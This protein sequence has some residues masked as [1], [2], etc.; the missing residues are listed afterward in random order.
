MTTDPF[1][2]PS[3]ESAA[4]A[5]LGKGD[6]VIV[7]AG[8]PV[9]GNVTEGVAGDVTMKDLIAAS[10]NGESQFTLLVV[11]PIDMISLASDISELSR[12]GRKFKRIVILSHAGGPEASPSIETKDGGK[13]TPK[14]VTKGLVRAVKQALT[15][16]GIV[17]MA[18][19]GY[20]YED[21]K[22]V[23]G[24]RVYR[25]RGIDP[26]LAK[27][28][29]EYQ[30]QW[31]KRLQAFAVLFGHAVFADASDSVPSARPE[32]VGSHRKLTT[33]KMLPPKPGSTL[34]EWPPNVPRIG[35]SPEGEFYGI[36]K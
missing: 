8:S 19:C 13:I 26:N 31:L 20:Y 15:P 17:I 27:S 35:A 29:K 6:L 21:M 34:Q 32:D 14:T 1:A 23:N 33:T 25:T 24:L 2:G 12:Q 9:A 7:M 10:E 16:N 30:E 18:T 4:E 5:P 11:N 22:M 3:V 36:R 28:D